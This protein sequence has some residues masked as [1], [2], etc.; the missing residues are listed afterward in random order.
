MPLYSSSYEPTSENVS[1]RMLMLLSSYY[2][3]SS[4]KEK[5]LYR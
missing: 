4:E 3:A 2:E 1:M 5:K